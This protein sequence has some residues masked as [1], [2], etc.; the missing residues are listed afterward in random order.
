MFEGTGV[1]PNVLWTWNPRYYAS[2]LKAKITY[3][4]YPMSQTEVMPSQRD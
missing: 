3:E 1:D 2:T 4:A